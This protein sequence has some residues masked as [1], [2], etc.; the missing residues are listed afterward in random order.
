MRM[1]LSV[2]AAALAGFATFAPAAAFDDSLPRYAPY[3]SRVIH[4]HVYMP[5]YRHVYHF[6]GDSYRW[7]WRHRYYRVKLG[8]YFVRN[9]DFRRIRLYR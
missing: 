8:G 4:H 9:P 1:I 2:A 6:H 5:R 3:G 7:A